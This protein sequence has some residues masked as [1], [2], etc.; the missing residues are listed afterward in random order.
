MKTMSAATEIDAPPMTVWAVLTDL[1]SYPSKPNPLF[2]RHP[3]R[4]RSASGS[5]SEASTQPMA[6]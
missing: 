3:G 5:G 4:S 6:G 1:A 2:A